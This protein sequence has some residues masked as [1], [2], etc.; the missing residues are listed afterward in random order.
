V[1]VK[2][3]YYKFSDDEAAAILTK[4]VTSHRLFRVIQASVINTKH[5]GNVHLPNFNE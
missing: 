3:K 5:Q 1:C 4:E 2:I